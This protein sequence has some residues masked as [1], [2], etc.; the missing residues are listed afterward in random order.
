MDGLEDTPPQQQR[1]KPD[2]LRKRRKV[3]SMDSDDESLADESR[4]QTGGLERFA[5][6]KSA[7]DSNPP[8]VDLTSPTPAQDSGWISRRKLK[9]EEEDSSLFPTYKKYKKQKS[10]TPKAAANR[11]R[12]TDPLQALGKDKNA[13]KGRRAADSSSE[14]DEEWSGDEGN[15]KAFSDAEESDDEDE[16][17]EDD[18]DEVVYAKEPTVDKAKKAAESMLRQCRN[19][20]GKLREALSR[21]EQAGEQEG[22]NVALVGGEE[23]NPGV[24][25]NEGGC[26]NLTALSSPSKRTA[27][28]SYG[29]GSGLGGAGWR[30][31]D[32]A[33]VREACPRVSLKAYQ[34]VGV[35]WL[36]LLHHEKVSGVLA[37][38]MGLGK[39]VQTISFFSVLRHQLRAAN[40]R[41]CHCQLVVVPASVLSNWQGE[42]ARFA[43]HLNVFVYHGSADQREEIKDKVWRE[44]LLPIGEGGEQARGV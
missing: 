17:D 2:V 27:G 7:N 34:L 30:P 1:R 37:D 14:C 33:A 31:I 3:L 13:E 44:C 16:Q 12:A 26:L 35:N 19:L 42:F 24:G 32:E 40:S 9:E 41:A 10:N 38:D 8:V 21:W 43:P 15:K 39:T 11:V 25:G 23:A 20:S 5:F 18:E 22:G 29:G 4:S 6:H 28:S 36:L